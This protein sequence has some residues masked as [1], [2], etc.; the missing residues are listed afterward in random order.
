MQQRLVPEQ[1]NFSSSK[2]N[3]DKLKKEFLAS[4]E[5]ST[6]NRVK[7]ELLKTSEGMKTIYQLD[8]A[9]LKKEHGLKEHMI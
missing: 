5:G 6:E 8:S 7:R 2:G 9:E 4:Y 3:Q 1:T